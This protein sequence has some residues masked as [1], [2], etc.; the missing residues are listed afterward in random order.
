[1][2]CY[3]TA[4]VI[5]CLLLLSVPISGVHPTSAATFGVPELV[6]KSS[7]GVAGNARSLL[8]CISG[9]G[10]YVSFGSEGSNLVPN[11][12]RLYDVFVHDRETHTTEL[13]NVSSTG[14]Q[15][16]G[17]TNMASAISDDGWYVAFF[18]DATN[19]APNDRPGTTDVFVRD[20]TAGTTESISLSAQIQ[21]ET[22]C[23]GMSADGR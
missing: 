12:T 15:A 16:Q 21:S 18:S 9:D 7:S 23:G 11:D 4:V 6:S 3:L 1:M 2:W 10:R 20:R 17:T 5:H 8:P 14:E 22:R 19:L 13:I